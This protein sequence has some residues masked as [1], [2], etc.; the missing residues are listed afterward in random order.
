M[1]KVRLGAPHICSKVWVQGEQVFVL[2]GFNTLLGKL[3][4]QVGSPVVQPLLV[5][6]RQGHLIADV[7]FAK[8][9]YKGFFLDHLNLST[10]VQSKTTVEYRGSKF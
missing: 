4:G 10:L 5:Q 8:Y 7:G 9:Y 6:F 1:L 3:N 2:V